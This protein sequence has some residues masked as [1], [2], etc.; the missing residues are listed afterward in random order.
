MQR[1]SPKIS[2]PTANVSALDT[3]ALPIAGSHL[4]RAAVSAAVNVTCITEISL[5][6]A[7]VSALDTSALPGH[8]SLREGN[9]ITG[10]P[11]QS[12]TVTTLVLSPREFPY[13][14]TLAEMRFAEAPKSYD[15][16][17]F[18]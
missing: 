1:A 6:I 14:Y 15:C 9:C 11:K 16:T 10:L 2:W 3:S 12:A 4:G 17:D 18:I 8:R 5:P 7:N 13:L